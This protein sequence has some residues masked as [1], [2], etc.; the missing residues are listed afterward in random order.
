MGRDEGDS[1]C[2]AGCLVFGGCCGGGLYGSRVLVGE[3]TARGISA[4][5]CGQRG[6]RA[7]PTGDGTP[8]RSGEGDES[9]G[10]GSGGVNIFFGCHYERS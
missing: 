4:G 2:A 9:G 3:V 7:K 8:G 10:A 5:D 1:Q 6:S